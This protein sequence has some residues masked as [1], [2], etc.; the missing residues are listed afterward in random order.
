MLGLLRRTFSTPYSYARKQLY[1][2]LVRS[3]M[4]YCSQLWRPFLL[5]DIKMLDG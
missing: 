4:M 1:L 5:K 3:Q 2:M